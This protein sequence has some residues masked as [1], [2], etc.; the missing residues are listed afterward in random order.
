MTYCQVVVLI[1]CCLLQTQASTDTIVTVSSNAPQA[2]V[3]GCLLDNKPCRNDDVKMALID[4][5]KLASVVWGYRHWP[6]FL[7]M[8]CSPT[9]LAVVFGLGLA[10]SLILIASGAGFQH[11]ID[12]RVWVNNTSGQLKYHY[13]QRPRWHMIHVRASHHVIM[14]FWPLLLQTMLV[15]DLGVY[16]NPNSIPGQSLRMSRYGIIVGNA[17]FYLLWWV[18][19][20]YLWSACATDLI[21]STQGGL[22]SSDLEDSDAAL[23]LIKQTVAGQPEA[24]QQQRLQLMKDTLGY[25]IGATNQVLNMSATFIFALLMQIACVCQLFFIAVVDHNSLF[26]SVSSMNL[27]LAGQLVAMCYISMCICDASGNGCNFA[28]MLVRNAAENVIDQKDH[29]HVKHINSRWAGKLE[30]FMEILDEGFLK[31]LM[32]FLYTR[33]HAHQS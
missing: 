3:R 9:S 14:V 10:I 13:T 18:M 20:Y 26:G 21:M 12:K 1:L 4:A 27:P 30:V 8:S 28:N 31:M 23:K 25:V 15:L 29:N 22:G 11:H 16:L 7:W 2:T 5:D 32:D 6:S 24:T 17:I 33:S 19:L